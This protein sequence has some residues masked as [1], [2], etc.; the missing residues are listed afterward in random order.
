MTAGAQIYNQSSAHVRVPHIGESEAGFW[1]SSVDTGTR[2]GTNA[3]MGG[4][5]ADVR[6][7]KEQD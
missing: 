1:L 2:V 7:L 3:G 6:N 4:G 5:I